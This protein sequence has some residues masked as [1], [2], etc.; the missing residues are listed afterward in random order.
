MKT[1]KKQTLKYGD[2]SMLEDRINDLLWEIIFRPIV[3]Q[4]KSLLP[5]NMLP[6][7]LKNAKEA[8][9]RKALRSG[10]VQMTT[11]AKTGKAIFSL[12]GGRSSRDLADAFREFGASLNKTLGAYTC[13]LASVPAWVRAES[14]TYEDKSRKAHNEVKRIL[15]EVSSKADRVIDQYNLE[16]GADHAIA[17]V[18]AGW[19][20]S[21]KA[22]EIE[23]ELNAEGMK[24]FTKGLAKNAK[25]PIK[26]WAHEAIDRLRDRVE[27]N[28][29]RGYRADNLFESIRD[30]YGQT[31]S[32]VQLIARQETSNFM[33]VYR[34][35]RAKEAGCP[36]FIWSCTPD[37]K[38][39][40]AHK[41]HNKRA[42]FYDNPPIIDPVT[43]KRGLPGQ[44]FNCRCTDLPI[45]DPIREEAVGATR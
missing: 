29:I 19:K 42:F 3:K 25:I 18:D 28:A 26:E 41:A 7:E 5:K 8:P 31:K 33:S 36:R 44:D 24:V 6:D 22:L 9:L 20:E 2:W 45:L 38:V 35:A 1:L 11:D 14:A 39:R 40:K 23:L 21:A 27:E 43:G 37:N 15:R 4:I 10:A 12:V 16:K 17:S 34:A 13:P 32:R 30:E